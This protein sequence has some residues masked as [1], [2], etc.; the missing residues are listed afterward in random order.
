MD[1]FKIMLGQRILFLSIIIF[2]V[3]KQELD[4]KEFLVGFISIMLFCELLTICY[5]TEALGEIFTFISR[6][7]D[8]ITNFIV[9]K[10]KKI[11]KSIL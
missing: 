2:L 9:T 4:Y 5:I 3:I 6:K 7:T 8:I 11:V 1:I 10:I